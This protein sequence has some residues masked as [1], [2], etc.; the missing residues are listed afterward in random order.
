MGLER[1]ENQGTS[2]LLKIQLDVVSGS[3]VVHW[4]GSLN[5]PLVQHLADIE[6]DIEYV[7]DDPMGIEIS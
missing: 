6:L 4:E 3:K 1:V 2:F 7:A 5:N